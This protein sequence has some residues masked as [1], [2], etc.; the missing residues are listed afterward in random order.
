ML[1]YDLL[2]QRSTKEEIRERENTAN[3]FNANS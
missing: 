1:G 2:L 3:C